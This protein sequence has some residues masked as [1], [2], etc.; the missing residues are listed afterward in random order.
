MRLNPEPWDLPVPSAQRIVVLGILLSLP[1]PDEV[2]PFTIV[3]VA[4]LFRD[5]FHWDPVR[6]LEEINRCTEAWLRESVCPVQRHKDEHGLV[7]VQLPSPPDYSPEPLDFELPTPREIIAFCVALAFLVPED[8]RRRKLA[9]ESIAVIMH[10][11]FGWPQERAAE[12]LN[13]CGEIWKAD[14]CSPRF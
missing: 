10:D 6:A 12:E 4:E 2:Q 8:N 11:L 7:R 13:L 5:I 14:G 3:S 9:L 1:L